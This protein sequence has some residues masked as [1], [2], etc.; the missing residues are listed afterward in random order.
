MLKTMTKIQST[1]S[2]QEL[3][4]VADMSRWDGGGEEVREVKKTAELK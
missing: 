1:Q 4:I 2:K 3:S